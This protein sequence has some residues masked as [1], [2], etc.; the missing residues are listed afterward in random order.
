[1]KKLVAAFVLLKGGLPSFAYQYSPIYM[2]VSA[3]LKKK[4][5]DWGIYSC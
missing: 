4:N 1:M 3:R 5:Q 2:N